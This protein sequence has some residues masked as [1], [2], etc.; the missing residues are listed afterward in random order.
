MTE[1]LWGDEFVIDEKPKTK[2]ILNKIKEPKKEVSVVKQVKSTSSKISLD[3]KLKLI[4]EEV[5]RK[6]GSYESTTCL[7]TSREDLH[8]YIDKAIKNKIIAIDTETN[9]SL[10]P[11]TCMLMG[12]CIYTP[13]QKS[14]YIP[15]NHVDR[16]SG[17]RL[18]WQVTEQDIK[19]E[20][21]RL[22]DTYIVMHNGKFD[23]QV[24]KCTCGL[25][26]HIDWDTMIGAKLLDENERSAK[27]KDQY[28]EKIN[29][30]QEKYD[31]EELFE[32]I[33]YAVVD[34]E[35][36]ALY[37]ATDARITYELYLWQKERFE[38]PENSK[39]LNL[40]NT[41]EMPLVKVIAEMEL[42]GMSVDQDYAKLLS[43]KY[44]K[45][46]DNIDN[47]INR[48]LLDLKPQIDAWRLTADANKKQLSR[49][50]KEG[51]SKSEQ[52][53]D[54]I[55]LSSPT[56]LAI[57]F[58]DVLKCP[59]VS[60][61]SPR[62]TGEDELKAISKKLNLKICDLLLN[63]RE[64]V[65]LITTYIDVI[66]ELAKRWPDGRV[67][68]HFNQYG[69]KTGRL[70][71]SDPINF[72]NVPSG[73]K[74]IRMLFCASNPEKYVNLSDDNILKVPDTCDIETI[75]GWVNVKDIKNNDIIKTIDENKIEILSKVTYINI[76]ENFYEL[77][78]V[79]LE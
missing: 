20:F 2:K 49:N 46:L 57:L 75:R 30:E 3:E 47:D 59:Q 4:A 18:S 15:V 33:E 51:K 76:N 52:L 10:D 56:Q 58:Y 77:T 26:L 61:K 19:E 64:W 73:N 17:E 44:H 50:G 8:A 71:S 68:T 65:K 63:R 53:E 67:R 27:L 40:A 39:L 69:A 13:G 41:L 54:P 29:P 66:P 55:K 35:L 14:A 7:L 5:H 72:Q 79:N 32:N 24:I 78:L 38:Q 45:L 1:S 28:I 23:Y 21:S 48:E 74:E 70:S 62:G 6:L 31:I 34:P 9:N 22:S 11:I 37:A 43:A 60:K 12:G 16:K 42:N 25:E 36:F